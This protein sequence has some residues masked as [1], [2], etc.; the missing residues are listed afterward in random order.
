MTCACPDAVIA[1]LSYQVEVVT[2]QIQQIIALTDTFN[3]A[4]QQIFGGADLNAMSNEIDVIIN[5]IPTPPVFSLT[6]MAEYLTCPLTPL[7]APFIVASYL[8]KD[9]RQLYLQFSSFYHAQVRQVRA[10]YE[11]AYNSTPS[12]T[13]LKTIKLYVKELQRAVQDPYAF[14]INVATAQGITA[15][16]SEACPEI[17][18]SSQWAFLDFVQ[19]FT[20]FSFLNGLIPTS[21]IA[22]AQNLVTQIYAGEAKILAWQQVLTESV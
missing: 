6:A 7:A 20:G 13:T 9:P 22:S 4:L 19:T 21:L 11:E 14:T 16:V 3:Y 8:N 10:E 12:A 1:Q 15:Y 2:E 17:Y 18:N 5:A